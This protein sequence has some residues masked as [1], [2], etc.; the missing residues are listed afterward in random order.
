V[1]S[2]KLNTVEDL[3]QRIVDSVAAFLLTK[4]MTLIRIILFCIHTDSEF[5]GGLC[6]QPVLSH[7]QLA[8]TT[9]PWKR[10]RLLSG[11]LQPIAEYRTTIKSV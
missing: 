3:N 1:Y 2:K 10:N 4:Q 11:R 7:I 6:G 8:L 9:S 5:L